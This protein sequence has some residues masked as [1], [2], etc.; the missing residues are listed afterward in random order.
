MKKML[1][2]LLLAVALLLALAGCG[3]QNGAPKDAPGNSDGPVTSDKPTGE[4][5]SDMVDPNGPITEDTVRNH[6]VTP[7][8]E[9]EYSLTEEGITI[10]RYKGS[11]TIVV[12]P[13]E[14]EQTPVTYFDMH[15]FG[16]DS[17]VRGVHIPASIKT[18]GRLTKLF[19]DNKN[20]EIIISDG[21]A[22]I[23]NEAFANCTSLRQV[24]LG[25]GLLELGFR[26]FTGCSQLEELHLP[27]SL[28]KI[29]LK[30]G[31]II[32]SLEINSGLTIY[33]PEGSY[34]EAFAKEFNIPFVAEE[35]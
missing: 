10:H 35:N 32:S 15:A 25:E 19:K 22:Y 26:S 4:T 21:P 34:A 33:A 14:I 16:K 29:H 2:F 18:E 27:K 17:I 12:V 11:D 1:V 20:I 8:E 13:D 9:F 28:T 24:F 23:T 31:T 30:E 7:A 6:A 3:S 5:P